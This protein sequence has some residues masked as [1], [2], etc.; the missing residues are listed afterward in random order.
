MGQ[1]N[2]LM[3]IGRGVLLP[4]KPCVFFSFLAAIAR[5]SRSSS[6]FFSCERANIEVK[7]EDGFL[8]TAEVLST[9]IT[10]APR[11]G[12]AKLVHI[13]ASL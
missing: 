1:N 8:F 6:I 10:Q 2:S 13:N 11:T 9:R 12:C 7:L 4:G 3:C 5:E